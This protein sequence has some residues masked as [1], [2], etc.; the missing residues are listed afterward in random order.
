MG[1]DQH[2]FAMDSLLSAERRWK[3][4]NCVVNQMEKREG[5]FRSKHG[6]WVDSC[7]KLD[8][9]M[10]EVGSSTRATSS[11]GAGSG[12]IGQQ[13]SPSPASKMASQTAH[14]QENVERPD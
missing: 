8:S 6:K 7:R 3:L 13:A 9:F 1:S 14:P 10:R 11:A 5:E 4:F 2:G 12:G